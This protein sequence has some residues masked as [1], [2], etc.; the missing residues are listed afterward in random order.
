MAIGLMN[1]FSGFWCKKNI[2]EFHLKIESEKQKKNSI[3][4]FFQTNFDSFVCNPNFYSIQQ[5]LD[6]SFHFYI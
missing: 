6:G 1:V 5:Q 2:N 3:P 4:E